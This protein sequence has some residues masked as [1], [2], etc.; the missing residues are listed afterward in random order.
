[1]QRLGHVQEFHTPSLGPFPTRSTV[2][3]VTTCV[4]IAYACLRTYAGFA[5]LMLRPAGEQRTAGVQPTDPYPTKTA[6]RYFEPFGTN[7]ASFPRRKVCCFCL[8]LFFAFTFTSFAFPLQSVS[9]WRRNGCEINVV[10][11]RRQSGSVFTR[12]RKAYGYDIRHM[13]RLTC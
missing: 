1:M 4:C 5:Y 12:G 3:R 2:I 8:C 7:F 13:C 11:K 10:F 6:E 9:A